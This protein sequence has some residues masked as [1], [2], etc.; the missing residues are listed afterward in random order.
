MDPLDGVSVF[1]TVADCGSF[2]AA[3][4]KLGCSKST[5]SEQVARLEHRIGARLLNRSPRAVTLTEAG[6]A[7]LCQ[8][9]DVLDRVR[10]AE[11]AALAEATE[12]RGPLRVSVPEPFASTHLAPMLPEFMESH[13][14]VTLELQVTAEVSDLVA[15]GY[16]LAIR[17]CPTNDPDVIVRRLGETRVIVAAAPSLF[18]GRPLPDSPEALLGLPWLVNSTYPERDQWTFRRNDDEFRVVLTPALVANSMSVLRQL[19]LAGRGAA[20]LSEYALID[21]FKAGRLIRLLPDWLVVDVPVLAVY[22]DNRRISAKVREFVEFVAARLDP[23]SLVE[24]PATPGNAK[25]LAV[26]PRSQNSRARA[27]AASRK[28]VS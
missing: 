23:A 10:R 18:A 4:E 9:D 5:A 8:I 19:V 6:R 22:A 17:L 15:S 21:D 3:A 16:D 13:P 2:S 26:K 24:A 27:S 25:P 14:E 7:Y 11:K 12:Q 1:I 20:L 28:S